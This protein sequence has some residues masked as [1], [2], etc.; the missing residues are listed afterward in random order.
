[1]PWARAR[2][3]NYARGVFHGRLL[4]VY[5]NQDDEW[6]KMVVDF[7]NAPIPNL[8]AGELPY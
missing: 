6:L 8:D 2:V 4:L 5:R 1:M 7:S 3:L